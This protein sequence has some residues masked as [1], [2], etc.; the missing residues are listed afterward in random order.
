MHE[1]KPHFKIYV[2]PPSQW[3]NVPLLG[4]AEK[5]YDETEYELVEVDLCESTV[6]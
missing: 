4:L 5:G 1:G 6:A 2:T 3:A